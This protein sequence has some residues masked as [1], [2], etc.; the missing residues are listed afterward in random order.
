MR[1]IKF[2]LI[3]AGLL[4]QV[5]TLLAQENYILH[6]V[7]K[8]QGLYSISRIYGVTEQEIIDLNPGSET[9]IKA[10]EQLRIPR[11][12][13][14]SEAQ[15]TSEATRTPDGYIAH[16]VL[17]GETVYR[18]TTI[19]GVSGVDIRSA[20]PS[21]DKKGLQ[22]GQIIYIPVDKKHAN[23]AEPEAEPTEEPSRQKSGLKSVIKAVSSAMGGSDVVEDDNIKVGGYTIKSA[24]DADK[25]AEADARKAEKKAAKAQRNADKKAVVEQNAE[26]QNSAVKKAIDEAVSLQKMDTYEPAQC[27]EEHVVKRFE[28]VYSL[29]RRYG[30]TQEELLAANPD[31]A[32]NGLKKG[33][34]ICIPYSAEELAA[35]SVENILDAPA[36]EKMITETSAEKDWSSKHSSWDGLQV[37]LILPFQ[38]DN[39][40]T[41]NTDRVKMVEFYEGFLLAV[42]SLKHK[43]VSLELYV[44]DSGGSA[45]SISGIL[46]KEEMAHMD[47]I[48]GPMH[49]KHVAEAAAFAAV[50]E[51]PL[52]VPFSRSV[53]Q[54]ESNP[55]VYQV[56][57][58]QDDLDAAAI[59]PFFLTFHQPN[60]LFFED[61]TEKA[62]PF[63][64]RLQKEL[65]ARDLSYTVLPADTTSFVGDIMSYYNVDADN[66][67]MMTSSDEKSLTR[68][69]PVIQLMTRDTTNTEG[70]HL[71]GYPQY[72]V[73]SAGHMDQ[74]HE[75]DTWFYTSFYTN[76]L[77][78]DAVDF[79]RLFRRTYSRD[80]VNR[81]PKYAILGFDTGY[82]FLSAISRH[83]TQPASVTL[84]DL[85]AFHC[86]TIQTGFRFERVNMVG[87]YIN[88]NV[89]LIH[90]GEDNRVYKVEFDE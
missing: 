5:Q 64:T 88:H 2:I 24:Y 30:I 39:S 68:M 89:Y 49:P 22:A 9:V 65:K 11:K 44:Y 90:I 13:A 28:T 48:F 20:N 85:S 72:Q 45:A 36:E 33:Q 80:I 15:K 78:P 86:P 4:L 32:T 58:S 61:K 38:L 69:L 56:N 14:S 54:I 7:L 50:H 27:R 77:L 57:A 41:S 31:V 53:D 3:L 35:Q 62:D 51:I 12:P 34:T 10:G 19:Y 52:V 26:A 73:Y 29:A 76:N 43:G 84:S 17:P 6:T 67:V 60:I 8:G 46:D 16:K 81:Y 63:C 87:G 21:L 23:A 18:L 55:M 42:D 83:S 79:H 25:K 66:I 71:F 40:A 37:A 59:A 74:F 70:L 1:K 47:I 75:V 82:Y